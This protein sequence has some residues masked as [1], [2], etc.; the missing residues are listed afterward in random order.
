V[1]PLQSRWTRSLP[2]AAA[3]AAVLYVWWY[4]AHAAPSAWS[5]FDQL[6]LAARALVSGKDPYAE[7][8]ARFPWPLYYPLPAVLLALPVAVLPMAGA[9]VVFAGV[10]AGLGVWA[11]LRYRPHAWPW[12]CSVPFIYAVQR[13]QWAPALLAAAL[14][15]GGL[16]GMLLAVKPNVAGAIFAFRPSRAALVGGGAIVLVSLALQPSWPAAWLGAIRVSPHIRAPVLL[17]SG[18]LLA[19]ALLR[20]RDP[21]ARLL[22]VLAFVPQTRA[23]YEVLPLGLVARTRRQALVQALLANVLALTT[24]RHWTAGALQ[25]HPGGVDLYD[26]AKFDRSWFPILLFGYLPALWLVLA[27]APVSQRRLVH[28]A[29]RV[30]VGIL[31]G[32]TGALAWLVWHGRASYML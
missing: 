4:Y 3:L 12:L 29:W 14:I 13:G 30:A 25:L 7:V 11:I 9:R 26:P 6:W 2:L 21:G 22:G 28:L 19:L 8:A 1:L 20:W 31:V 24:T 27:P 10:T 5:D 32:I 15:P 18:F 16:P 23:L 17:P